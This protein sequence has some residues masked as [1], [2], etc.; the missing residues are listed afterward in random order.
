MC[1]HLLRHHE[2]VDDRAYATWR[3][4][5]ELLAEIG[6]CLFSQNLKVS[7]QLPASLA[8]RTLAAW[9]RDDGEDALARDETPGDRTVRHGAA[10]L[11]P[12]GLAIQN[13]SKSSD[14]D[15]V[16]VELDAWQ[17][18]AALDAADERQL[19]ND[20]SPPQAQS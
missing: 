2:H 13:R 8:A 4:D 10:D 5:A 11:A 12:I 14:A 7:V 16:T 17:I 18:G 20:V 6:R 1:G 3:D 9:E 15:Q 19:L